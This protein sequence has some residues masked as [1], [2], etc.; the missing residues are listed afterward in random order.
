[1]DVARIERLDDAPLQADLAS[2]R[3]LSSKQG[4]AEAMGRAQWAFG[5]SFFTHIFSPDINE[6]TKYILALQ[7][8]GL[9]APSKEP[10]LN[11]QMKGAKAAYEQHAARMLQMAKWNAPEEFARK[12]VDLETRIAE[13]SWDQVDRN[14]LSKTWNVMTVA[15]LEALAPGFSWRSYLA[16]AGL[17]GV[18]ETVVFEKS[19]FPK[20][21]AIFADTPLDTLKAWMAFHKADRAAPYLSRRFQEANFGFWG[22]M[23]TRGS[24]AH[25][26][27]LEGGLESLPPR[28][29]RAVNLVNSTLVHPVGREYMARF[30]PPESKAQIEQMVHRI[31]AAMMDRIRQ[32]QW[33][34][35]QT[36]AEALAKIS[37][38]RVGIGYPDEWRDYSGLS[39]KSDDLYGNVQKTSAYNWAW[40]VG[41]LGRPVDREEWLMAPQAV[42]GQISH[43]RLFMTLSAGILQPPFFDPGAD[44][45]V[46]YGA[47]GGVIGHELGHLFDDQGWKMDA[48]GMMRNWWAPEDAALFQT[49]SEQMVRMLESNEALPGVPVNGRMTLSETLANLFG[50]E[51]ALDA[52]HA[53]LGGKPAPVLDGFTG[54]Q[55]FFL[56]FAQN[57]K[58]KVRDE[59]LKQMPTQ[60]PPIVTINTIARNIDEW[61][62]AFGVKPGDELYLQPKERIRIW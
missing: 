27:I 10:Y 46:N 24:A 47:I 11:E 13:V 48:K 30:F 43:T 3:N 7:Q 5:H 19:A 33:M 60:P 26:D 35:P 56:A 58:A 54:D 55:R 51:V 59:F 49:R 1:M 44:A 25:N 29:L 20:I 38:V 8:A 45:A 41:K 2:I 52:Y 22:K 37:A 61:Y 4:V 50:W 34:Q 42:G 28:G 15:E 14:N 57:G 21:A 39:L 17:G 12:I 62:T 32:N 36:K 6:P 9:G 23:G 31:K 18:E 53:S 40:Q 16:G